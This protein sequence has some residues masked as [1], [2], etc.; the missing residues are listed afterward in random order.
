MI[1]SL[2]NLKQTALEELDG[3]SSI[4]QLDALVLRYF[5]RSG[6]LL[7][8]VLRNI[9]NLS[10]DQRRVLGRDANEVK[11][12]IWKLID[13]KRNKL[14]N[15]GKP[16]F[17]DLTA[18]T[19]VNLGHLH[20]VTLIKQEIESIF[21]QMGYAVMLGPEIETDYYNFEALNIPAEHPAR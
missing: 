5:G 13:E 4:E 8:N 10:E 7:N 12:E 14:K 16:E 11:V 1:D 6:G 20:P 21:R 17:I 18:H 9:K 2:K 19:S 3:V 15:L